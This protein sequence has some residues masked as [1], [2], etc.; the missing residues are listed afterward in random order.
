MWL[1]N[2]KNPLTARTMVNRLW[3]QLF[4]NGLAETLEDLGT[5]GIAPTHREL[6]DNLSYRFMNDFNWSVKKLLKE[7]IMSATYRQDS[8][9]NDTLQQKD[10]NNKFYAR[11]P[12]I[13][14]SAEQLRDQALAVSHLLN[15]KM[16][17]K[18]VMPFQPDGIWRSPYNGDVWT[19][20]KDN[21]QYRRALYTFWKRTAPYPSAITFDGV[22]RDVCVTRRIR[23]NTPLQ[24]LTALN[25]SAFFVMARSFA[26]QM[27]QHGGA[28][29]AQQIE[30]GYKAMM[31]KTITEKKL[32]AL[33][34][35]YATSVEEYKK[36]KPAASEILGDKKKN[37]LPEAAAMVVVANAMLNLDEWVNK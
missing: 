33:T 16:F 27:Q 6:L 21:E 10:P 34:N 2:K 19:M 28:A 20:S 22:S 23:T 31:Y 11:G 8:K 18:P 14:L 5:Q 4:G 24:A 36:N 1:T 37:A 17:G 26:L 30:H 29:V 12:R 13:R 32:Q 7:M 9:T 3:E 35:L 25:D 15:T